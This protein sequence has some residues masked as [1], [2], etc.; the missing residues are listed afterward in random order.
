MAKLLLVIGNKNYS[1]WSLRPY[2]A[3]AQ[4][5]IA[6]DEK[7]V[8]LDHPS[9]APALKKFNA[10]GRVPVLVDGKTVVWDSLAIMEYLAE[11]FPAK[12]LWPAN[13]AARA[14]A[15]SMSA[16]MHSGFGAL[17]NAC[18]MNLRRMP[19]AF[20]VNDAVMADVARIEKLWSECRK[21]HGKDGPFLCGKFGAVD[22]MFT[23]V[24]TRLETYAIPVRN[25]T[26]RYMEALFSTKAFQAWKAA[27]LKEKWIVP[28]DEV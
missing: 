4:A 18:P 14:M 26:R 7:L 13:R 3:L 1:S 5:G 20:A 15:R 9:F 12:N 21:A 11:R 6:F 27:A 8:R 23:P 24:A 2:M 16:E 17:R 22:A 28:H 10:A 25:D 19:Q